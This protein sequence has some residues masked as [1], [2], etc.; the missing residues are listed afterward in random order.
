MGA[1]VSCAQ[2]DD[3]RG[4]V[5]KLVAA[6]AR[7]VSGN[8]EAS[9]GPDGGAFMQ[10]IL[11]RADDPWAASAVH[12]VEAFGPVATIMPYR[13]LADA[14]ALAN[15]GMGSLALSLFSYSPDAAR[16]FILGAAPFHGRMLVINRDN[17]ADS[18]GHGIAPPRTR[19]R[20]PR[21]RRRVGGDGRGARGQALHA[22]HR[23][24]VDPGDDRRDQQPVH[25]RRA[26]EDPRRA[27]VPQAD[28][29]ASHRRHAAAPPAA[30]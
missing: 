20:R 19:P 26:Q 30:P 2:R 4:Q 16:D 21:A 13:D 3:V 18:T 22:A 17:A 10:P 27:P 9:T 25:P 24:P 5:E 28:E 15:R 8:L 6:G 29:R 11:L 1:L 7:I 14:V 12:D 23:A